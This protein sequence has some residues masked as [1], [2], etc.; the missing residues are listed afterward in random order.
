MQKSRESQGDEQMGCRR[1]SS[2]DRSGCSVGDE[3]RSS[4]E[5]RL[6]AREPREEEKEDKTEN[7]EEETEAEADE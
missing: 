1:E 3:R 7:Q 6:V 4:S 2:A 5:P